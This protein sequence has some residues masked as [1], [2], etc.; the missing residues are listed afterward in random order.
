MLVRGA[1]LT[2]SM[3]R[4]LIDQIAARTNVQHRALHAGHKRRRR[5]YI[6]HIVT[7]H[8][9]PACEE[10]TQTRDAGALFLMIGATENTDW[11]PQQLERDPKGY[12]CTGRDL[13]KWQAGRE[14]FALETNLPGLFCAGDVRHGSIKR[15]ASGVG[16][17]SMSISFMHE[18]LAL[19]GGP[20]LRPWFMAEAKLEFPEVAG[21]LVAE[22]SVYEDDDSAK[23]SW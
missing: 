3:S 2:L 18:Y 6:E 13:T 14:P 1:G 4:Y 16:E 9:P 5:N 22:L 7:T 12:I 11:L 23:K 21:K 8:R 20:S 19:K 15:V 17:G 10:S